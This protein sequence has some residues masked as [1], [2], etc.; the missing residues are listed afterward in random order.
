M[1]KG[2]LSLGVLIMTLWSSANAQS[3]S[4]TQ[5]NWMLNCQGC[6]GAEGKISAINT[7]VLYG[8]VATFLSV[9]G[10]R[11]YLASVP[12]V[13]NAPINDAEKADLMTWMINILDPMHKPANFKPFTEEEM[14]KGRENP[15][16]IRAPYKREE[17][18]A[19]MGR[20]D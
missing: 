14:T 5:Y 12:G 20:K 16:L 17:L 1:N 15:L 8:N 19:K 11:E 9:E 10:G 18:L 13:V 7:P 4:R 6:H 2:L 3:L